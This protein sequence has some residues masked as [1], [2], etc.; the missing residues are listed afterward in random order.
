MVQK[1][2]GSEEMDGVKAACFA[3][4][5]VAVTRA[6]GEGWCRGPGTWEPRCTLH[7]QLSPEEKARLGASVASRAGQGTMKPAEEN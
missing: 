2:S 1:L 4:P 3:P 6:R 5:P 7:N